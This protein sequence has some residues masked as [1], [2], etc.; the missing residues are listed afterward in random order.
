MATPKSLM[1]LL[2]SILSSS[3]LSI[4]GAQDPEKPENP[5]NVRNYNFCQEKSEEPEN[6]WKM[7]CFDLPKNLFVYYLLLSP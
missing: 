2:H 4:Q 3:T 1:L 7:T 5:E 6:V